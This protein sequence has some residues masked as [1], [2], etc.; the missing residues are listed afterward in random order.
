MLDILRK[1]PQ[2]LFLIDGAGALLS[3]AMLLAFTF[4]FD[5]FFG[6]PKNILSRLALLPFSFAIY[7]LSCYVRPLQRWRVFL[8]TIALAN[9]CYCGITLGL[10]FYY[11]EQ[12]TV[13]GTWYFVIEKL[14]VVPLAIIEWKTSNQLYYG[15]E[16]TSTD[17]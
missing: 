7:S 15:K 14:I 12:I 2:K 17:S 1:H 16:N 6:I 8:K 13:L 3:L 4:A 11:F 10:L 9:F 5:D